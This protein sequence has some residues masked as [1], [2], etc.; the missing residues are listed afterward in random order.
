MRLAMSNIAWDIQED[1]A[2]AKLLEKFSVD[3]IDVAPSKYFPNPANTKDGEIANV[4]KWWADYGIEI[5][6]MQ[7]LLFGTLGLNVFGDRQSQDAMLEHLRAVCRI[8]A[9]LGATRLVFGSPKNR[10]RSGLGNVQTLERAVGFFRRLGD[11][12]KE[13]GVFVC[14]EPN[15]ARYGANFMMTSEETS[16]VVSAVGH[17][18]I[19]MQFDSGALTINGESPK[20]VLECSAKLIG[21]VHASEPDLVPLGDGGTDHQLMCKALNGYLPDHLVTI[22]MVATKAEPHLQSIQRAL[23]YAVDCY[24]TVPGVTR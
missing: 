9:G 2:V 3:A 8:G 6:G 12:A 14:L 4:R 10:D 24:R 22:E 7:S 19:R 23:T 5:T 18:S 13:H 1:L 11:A 20:A 17:D 15:P 16:D 21:H